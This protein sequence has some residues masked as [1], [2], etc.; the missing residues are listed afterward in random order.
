MAM[1]PDVVDDLW[2]TLIDEIDCRPKTDAAEVLR[3][4][5]D[6]ITTEL[7]TMEDEQ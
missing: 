3:G 1:H 6:R 7:Q 5:R 2:A 4:L